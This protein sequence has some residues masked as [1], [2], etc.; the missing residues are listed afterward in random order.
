[1]PWGRNDVKRFNKTAAESDELAETWLSTANSC[2]KANGE[3]KAG[4]CVRVAN[5]AVR[6]KLQKR[7]KS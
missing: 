3:K 7:N 6:K 2:I 4:Y 5:A 1:M